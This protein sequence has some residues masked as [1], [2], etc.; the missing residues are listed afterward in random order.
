M[1]SLPHFSHRNLKVTRLSITSINRPTITG[2]QAIWSY[3]WIIHSISNKKFY[4]SNI[5]HTKRRCITDNYRSTYRNIWL[6]TCCSSQIQTI[7]LITWCNFIQ[8]FRDTLIL[9]SSV[10]WIIIILNWISYTWL[11]WCI[12]WYRCRF[13]IWAAWFW[14]WCTIWIHIF[15]PCSIRLTSC[16]Y[17]RTICWT[18]WS[19]W[20][21]YINM[22]SWIICT[23]IICTLFI[24]ITTT[25]CWI[26][27]ISWWTTS[28]TT[29]SRCTIFSWCTLLTTWCCA[30]FIRSII[31]TT[32]ISTTTWTC[33]FWTWPFSCSTCILSLI[34]CCTLSPCSSWTIV[35][36]WTITTCCTI[37][38]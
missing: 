31:S 26:W 2:L 38:W 34:G 33:W 22:I 13:K 17:C 10:I 4:I 23:S 8:S 3:N 29:W 12:T 14:L 5:L 21:I 18:Y 15:I 16:W 30:T 19:C 25:L 7:S 36:T 35:S 9:R 24:C 28:T 1:R 32:Y 11:I 20:S 27:M 6:Y 37:L